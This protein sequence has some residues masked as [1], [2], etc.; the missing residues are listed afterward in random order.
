[1]HRPYPGKGVGRLLLR[2]AL[3]RT[4]AAAEHGGIAFLVLDAL[5]EQRAGFYRALGFVSLPSQPLRMVISTA[6]MRAA[7]G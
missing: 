5:D 7:M 6:T 2:D 4:V 1:M 3:V